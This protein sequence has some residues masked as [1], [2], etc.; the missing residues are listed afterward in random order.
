MNNYSR[1]HGILRQRNRTDITCCRYFQKDI[2]IKLSLCN[3]SEAHQKK[4][5]K[6]FS[7]WLNISTEKC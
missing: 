5:K 7:D 3:D 6:A 2:E 4:R 1:F